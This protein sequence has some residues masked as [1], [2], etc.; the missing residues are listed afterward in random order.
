MRMTL[1]TDK[2]KNYDADGELLGERIFAF[3]DY[4]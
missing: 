4:A 2:I 3:S 1:M